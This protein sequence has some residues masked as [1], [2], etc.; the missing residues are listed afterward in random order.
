V[1]AH[2]LSD[3]ARDTAS[4]FVAGLVVMA[5]G[6]GIALYRHFRDRLYRHGVEIRHTQKESEVDPVFPEYPADKL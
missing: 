1:D 3:W 4:E 5:V 2:S 6:G